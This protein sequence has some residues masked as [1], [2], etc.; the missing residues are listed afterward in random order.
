MGM[1]T[2]TSDCSLSLHQTTQPRNNDVVEHAHISI[3][4]LHSPNIISH[5]FH[6]GLATNTMGCHMCFIPKPMSLYSN[7]PLDCIILRSLI[8]NSTLF[9]NEYQASDRVGVAQPNFVLIHDEYDWE[10]EHQ[11]ST[12][13]DFLFFKT[14][15]F[16]SNVF[17]DFV[18]T[19]SACVSLS[20]DTPI[21]DHSQNTQDSSPSSDNQEEQSFIENPLDFSSSFSRNTEGEH[22]FFSST[23]LLYSSNH[24]DA[25]K[26][27]KFFDLGYFD[28]CTSSSYHDIDSTVVNLNKKL[29]YDNLSIDKVKNP[30]IVK[31]FQSELMVMSGPLSHKVGFTSN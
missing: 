6:A 10:L 2:V 26:H 4:M 22:S 18:I 3:Q 8:L 21:V 23:P 24:E 7:D 19:H 13:D 5:N 15:P 30:H 12:K 20:M 27:P 28:L 11:P 1:V 16:F 9:V 31:A 14:P 17:G 29:V 25:G